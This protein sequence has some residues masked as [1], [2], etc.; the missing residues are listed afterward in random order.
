LFH[1][2]RFA[3]KLGEL[4]DYHNFVLTNYYKEPAVDFQSTLDECMAF[5]ELLRPMMTDVTADLHELRRAGCGSTPE[6]A[7]CCAAAL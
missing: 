5:A 7:F 3:S 6:P 2:E 4:L 1:R